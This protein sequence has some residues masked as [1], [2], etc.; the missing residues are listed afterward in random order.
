[1]IGQSFYKISKL[2]IHCKNY[3]AWF[4]KITGLM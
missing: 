2:I 1:M 3:L 4:E